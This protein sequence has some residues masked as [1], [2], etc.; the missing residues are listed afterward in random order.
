[1][2]IDHGNLELPLM[3]GNAREVIRLA[4]DPNADTEDLAGIVQRDQALAG[5]LLRVANSTAYCGSEPIHSVKEAT[6]RLGFRFVGRAALAITL[7]NEFFQ[8]PGFEDEAQRI[9]RH[10]LASAFYAR[11]IARL[12]RGDVDR[13]YLCG[14][15]HTIGKPAGLK[16]LTKLREKNRFQMSD[17]DL[18]RLN[19]NEHSQLGA[20]L[21]NKWRL[22]D[23]IAQVCLWYHTPDRAEKFRTD[24]AVTNLAHHLANRALDPESEDE[25]EIRTASAVEMLGLYPEEVEELLARRDEIRSLVDA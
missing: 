17:D 2:E 6:L 13:S 1:M 14:L 3:P 10:A 9:A 18:I 8:V 5:H 19:D 23:V 16:L 11:E 12:N 21:L 24:A 4:D 15:L 22:P 20:R 7:K 25:D